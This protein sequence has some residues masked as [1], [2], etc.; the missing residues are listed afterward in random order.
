MPDGHADHHARLHP[1]ALVHLVDEV[2]QHL[3][4]DL[5]VGDDAVLQRP[6]GLDVARRAAD[7]A[8]GLEPD[9]E[10]ASVLHVDRDDRG[11]VEHDA[12][13]ADVDERV[14][15]PEIDRHVAAHD[16]RETLVSTMSERASCPMAVRR[17]QP[18]PR[19]VTR[20]D[21]TLE[22]GEEDRDLAVGRFGPSL[23]WT[24]FS[25]RSMPRSPRIVPGAASRGFV[26]PIIVRTTFQVSS[27]PSTTTGAADSR[28]ERDEIVVE[29]LALVLRVVTGGGLAS[30][31]RSSNA[32]S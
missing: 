31:V 17:R 9:G 11:L 29:R 16:G 12:A 8:L 24:R 27:G 23:P 28:D 18:T 21:Q 19:P 13:P 10:R 7:H 15:G 20:N 14:G 2:A 32:T 3:L 26:A 5:E 30:M 4:A 25:V 1:P 6:D 22:V